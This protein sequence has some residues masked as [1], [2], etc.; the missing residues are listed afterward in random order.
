MC[1]QIRAV[2]NNVHPLISDAFL[3]LCTCTKGVSSDVHLEAPGGLPRR[4]LPAEVR[5]FQR[6]ALT[7]AVEAKQRAAREAAVRA[8]AARVAHAQ[9][10]VR[11]EAK[12][13]C[14]AF[15]IVLG[16]LSVVFGAFTVQ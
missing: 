3:I 2:F 14:R 5:D 13:C 1:T 8:E 11:R 4:F 16:E 12:R 15:S 10:Q 7:K 9:N 6:E